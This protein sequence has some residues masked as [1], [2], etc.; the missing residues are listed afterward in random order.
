MDETGL[1]AACGRELGAGVAAEGSSQPHAAASTGQ[2]A[3]SRAPGGWR[4]LVRFAVMG[5]IAA[6]FDHRRAAARCAAEARKPWIAGVY[7]IAGVRTLGERHAPAVAREE[8]ARAV[9]LAAAWTGA[10]VGAP[11]LDPGC[12]YASATLAPHAT[13][14]VRQAARPQPLYARVGTHLAA[15]IVRASPR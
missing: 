13:G 1:H 12:L 10:R 3:R 11:G 8:T 6:L 5:S 14:L 15:A 2:A 4:A 9:G 7:R